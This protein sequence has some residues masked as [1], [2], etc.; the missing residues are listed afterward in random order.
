MMR[1]GYLAAVIVGIFSALPVHAVTTVNFTV[2]DG[3]KRRAEGVFSY[4]NSLAGV[5]GFGDLDSF[6]VS[7]FPNTRDTEL[8]FTYNLTDVNAFD[9]YLYFA[10]D[11]F[12]NVFVPGNIVGAA[13]NFA[14]I[15]SASNLARNEGFY[16]TGASSGYLGERSTNLGRFYNRMEFSRF[17]IGIDPD[18]E[19]EGPVDLI[20]EPN[21]WAMLIAGFGLTGAVMRRRRLTEAFAKL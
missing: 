10:Y 18:P 8:S 2:F 19:G 4:R 20:P 12:A 1:I 6:S 3:S 15:L 14:T 5:L 9:T 17:I 21:T 7:L 16:F 11:T 13:G